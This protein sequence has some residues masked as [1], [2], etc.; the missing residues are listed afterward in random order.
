MSGESADRDFME[1][2][3]R[4]AYAEAAYPNSFTRG[5]A[6]FDR[7]LASVKAEAWDEGALWRHN[8]SGAA[9]GG[10]LWWQPGYPNE[11]VDAPNPYR[12]TNG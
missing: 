4:V 6:E 11:P 1:T 9:G 7:W 2:E 3:V 8:A 10:L 12:K 5:L